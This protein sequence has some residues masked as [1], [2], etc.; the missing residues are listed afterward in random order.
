MEKKCI[1]FYEESMDLYLRCNENPSWV[2]VRSL[3]QNI[4]TS[5]RIAGVPGK[6]KIE[7]ITSIFILPRV[8]R[9]LNW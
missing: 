2:E 4:L 1:F 8:N 7:Q 3:I 6:I 9:L 5:V